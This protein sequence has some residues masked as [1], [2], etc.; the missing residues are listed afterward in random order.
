VRTV[1]RAA[2]VIV[3]LALA[4]AAAWGALQVSDRLGTSEP[5]PAPTAART[6][7]PLESLG[8]APTQPPWCDDACWD[9]LEPL[10]G[11]EADCYDRARDG[12]PFSPGEEISPG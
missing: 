9:D 8:P 3:L 2:I 5:T 1:R 7:E 11:N 12:F 4:V 10:C 6:P